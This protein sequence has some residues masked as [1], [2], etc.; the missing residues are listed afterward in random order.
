MKPPG[1][2][3]D[4]DRLGSSYLLLLSFLVLG[5]VAG[6]LFWVGWV[7][8]ALQFVQAI[9]R[10]GIQRG[11]RWWQRLLAW[12]HWPLFLGMVL[13]LLVVGGVAGGPVPGLAVACGA[14][15]F[16][17]GLVTCLAY[18]WIDLE[19]YEVA[20]GYKALHNPMKGQELAANL[21]RY[22]RHVGAPLLIAAT[23][24][25]VGG[26]ALLNQGLYATVGREWYRVGAGDAAPTFVD[27]LA[28]TLINLFRV[29]DLLGIAESYN[30]VHVTYVRQARWPAATLL[31]GFRSF[32]TLVLL[33]QIFASVRRGRLLAET[34]SDFW[35]PHPPIYERARGSLP[36]HGP[37]AVW[38]LLLSLRDID[39]L[40]AE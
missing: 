34:I 21:V 31:A 15:L 36:Q 22:G 24:A 27:F 20:R 25:L 16:F 29:V 1:Y 7:G 5:V 33:Q 2:L 40:T 14:I 4:L 10:A 17:L 28:Y 37:G 32:F 23:V 11:F 12:A 6:L 13:V 3:L 18:I 9:V 19:R 35:S 38:P 26:F 39:V 8:M 30:Y